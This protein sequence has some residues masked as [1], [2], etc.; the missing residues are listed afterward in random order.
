[1][2]LQVTFITILPAL[3]IH[4]IVEIYVHTVPLT[5]EAMVTAISKMNAV[6]LK[7]LQK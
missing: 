1:M 3:K 4:I 6:S 2:L 7:L 5:K